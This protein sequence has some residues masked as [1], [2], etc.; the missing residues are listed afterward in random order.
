[1]AMPH[2]D[3]LMRISAFARQDISERVASVAV[4]APMVVCVC[5][6]CLPIGTHRLNRETIKILGVQFPPNRF[7]VLISLMK[8][9]FFITLSQDATR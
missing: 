2:V 7:R 6:V 3:G 4:S 5:Q 8:M 1:M 9:T